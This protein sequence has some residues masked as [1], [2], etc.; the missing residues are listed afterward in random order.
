MVVFSGWSREEAIF[1]VLC[2]FEFGGLICTKHC[3]AGSHAIDIAHLSKGGS[4]MGL[5][6]G[7]SVAN[8]MATF[9]LTPG[10]HNVAAR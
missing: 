2:L 10:Q 6:V 7:P 4:P 8:D 3:V 9:P 5:S 1:C